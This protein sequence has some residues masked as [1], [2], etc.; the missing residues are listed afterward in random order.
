MRSIWLMIL[1]LVL[2]LILTAGPLAVT[3]AFAGNERPVTGLITHVDRVDGVV[4][5][6][7]IRFEVPNAV[8]DLDELEA[9]TFALIEYQRE[10]EQRTATRLVPDY[11][12]R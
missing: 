2:T 1:T 7:E 6:A 10:G 5:M 8:F 4:W 9:N 12:P 3:P 11:K